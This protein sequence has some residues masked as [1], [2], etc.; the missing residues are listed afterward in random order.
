MSIPCKGCGSKIHAYTGAKC[1]FLDRNEDNED[2]RCPC[3]R[4]IV[5][6]M[7]KDS[8]QTF[9]KVSRER[10]HNNNANHY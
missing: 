4:C 10:H 2:G 5:K 9:E 3:T 7:C 8:C 6:G 1:L